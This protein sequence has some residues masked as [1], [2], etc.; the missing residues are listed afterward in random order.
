MKNPLKAIYDKKERENKLRDDVAFLNQRIADMKAEHED[1]VN[2]YVRKNVQDVGFWKM[3][4]EELE[5]ERDQWS[6][7]ALALQLK[8]DLN[9]MLQSNEKFLGLVRAVKYI[10]NFKIPITDYEMQKLT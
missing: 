7:D 10:A 9:K 5:K 6:K 8:I 1:V 2:Q 4:Y 3:Q